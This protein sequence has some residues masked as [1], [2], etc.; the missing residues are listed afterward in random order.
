M[1]IAQQLQLRPALYA[2]TTAGTVMALV[3]LHLLTAVS[4]TAAHGVEA[5][6][7]VARS[8]AGQKRVRL[9]RIRLPKCNR[10]LLSAKPLNHER[11]ANLIFEM[12][13]SATHGMTDR[14]PLKSSMIH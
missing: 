10:S 1:G 9:C 5:S 11:L 8:H 7:V 6:Q 4:V 3:I 2:D 12:L 14:V 13:F